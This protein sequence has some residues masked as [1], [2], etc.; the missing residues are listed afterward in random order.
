MYLGGKKDGLLYSD[1]FFFLL[2]IHVFVTILECLSAY[3][4][5]FFSLGRKQSC[6]KAI[7]EW[8]SNSC[9][10]SVLHGWGA[11]AA[12]GLRCWVQLPGNCWDADVYRDLWCLIACSKS[13][14]AVLGGGCSSAVIIGLAF[15]SGKWTAHICLKGVDENIDWVRQTVSFLWIQL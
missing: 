11:R 12:E 3:A 6:Y 8:Y 2:N 14:T 1:F 5:E 15:C 7:S 9:A 10:L 4:L 13:V